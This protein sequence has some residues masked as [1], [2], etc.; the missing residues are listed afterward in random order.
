MPLDC[1]VTGI[2]LHMRPRFCASL[3]QR[4]RS[5]DSGALFVETM[6]SVRYGNVRQ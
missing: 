6:V 5:P 3:C 4:L 2:P 1:G